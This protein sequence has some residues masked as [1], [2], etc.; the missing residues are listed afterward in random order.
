MEKIF[1]QEVKKKFEVVNL[2][3]AGGIKSMPT[4]LEFFLLLQ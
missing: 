1:N 3:T 4:A 2:L